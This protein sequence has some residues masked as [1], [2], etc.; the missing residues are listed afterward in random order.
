MRTNFSP[1][2]RLLLISLIAVLS[3][4]QVA[5]A[6]GEPTILITGTDVSEFPVI[7]LTL[8]AVD[9]EGS[10]LSTLPGLVVSEAGTPVTVSDIS[11]IEAGVEYI[12]VIDANESYY[13]RDEP[14]GLTRREIVKDSILSF[15]NSYMNQSQMDRATIIVPG[16]VS[17]EVLVDRSP[18]HTTLIN[19][20]NFYEPESLAATP[21]D[22][23]LDLASDRA[24]DNLSEG[25]MQIIILF[26][27]GGQLGE[28]IEYEPAVK[29]AQEGGI[30]IYSAI[31]GARADEDEIENVSR[32][33]DPTGGSYIHLA[34]STSA[35]PLYAQLQ[36]R[37][38]QH[39]VEYRSQLATAG[40][41][42]VSVNSAGAIDTI[43]LEVEISAPSVNIDVVNIDPIKRSVTDPDAPLAMAVPS[44]QPI[45][46]SVG[47]PDGYP[48][49]VTQARLIVDGVEQTA[50]QDPV[51]N[52]GNQLTLDWDLRDVDEG[53]YNLVVRV[54]DELGI[55]G[56]SAGLQM[57]VEVS[58][59][60]PSEDTELEVQPT[61]AP[62]EPEEPESGS[63]VDNLGTVGI[64]VGGLVLIAAFSLVLI[65]VILVRRRSLAAASVVAP[66]GGQ[67]DAN[68]TKVM[69]PAFAAD[70]TATAYL[71]PLENAPDHSGMIPI[72][73][74]NVAI[75]RDANL[76][77]IVFSNKSVS[78]LHARIMF[79]GGIYQLYD[80]GSASG[81]YVNYEPVSLTPQNIQ[82]NDDIHFGQVHVRFHASGPAQDDD[83]TQIMQVPPERPG[84]PQPADDDLSTQPYMPDQPQS[85]GQPQQPSIKGD[86]EDDISTQPYMPHSPKR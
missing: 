23:M 31:L 45:K 48:R 70:K 37:S 50:V 29:K 56:V 85:P 76:A 61:I 28:Q 11:E 9:G 46:A 20:I 51:I 12:F 2:L 73:A 33:G 58:R 65:A 34:D 35:D 71:E 39:Q 32:L 47:W 38:T 40:S 36:E 3:G 53:E 27:D 10:R 5:S 19:E 86:D 79:R 74:E 4:L 67:A 16:E 42:T 18:F 15:A 41:H 78:R 82:D 26:T 83:A 84:E 1:S 22:D 75:G 63:L 7:R 24:A 68:A 25:R 30:P 17:G 64:I 72:S 52:S 13:D 43:D 80:E 14:G 54:T 57:I 8:V 77:Q 55:E 21:L 66:T 59:P 62:V 44:N 6:Q 60:P 69:R 49:T 81:T